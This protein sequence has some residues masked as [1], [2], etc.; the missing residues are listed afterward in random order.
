MKIL[1]CNCLF[2]SI[3]STSTYITFQ[4][5]SYLA[6]SMLH[7]SVHYSHRMTDT[8][9][10]PALRLIHGLHWENFCWNVISKRVQ[11]RMFW[12]FRRHQKFIL[13]SWV[14]LLL[15]NHVIAILAWRFSLICSCSYAI[16]S[17]LLFLKR[18]RKNPI[19][20]GRYQ[21]ILR[22]SRQYIAIQR[23]SEDF[24]SFKNPRRFKRLPK[25]FRR[26]M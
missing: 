15:L 17:L 21:G 20:N 25:R 6:Y 19:D 16:F 13:F 7:L 23:I 11:T 18:F 3:T 9:H 5:F 1:Q 14:R 4:F 2:I 26:V 24:K 8:L 22:E 12:L 10:Q